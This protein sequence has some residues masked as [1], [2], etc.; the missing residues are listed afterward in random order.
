M[1]TENLEDATVNWAQNPASAQL[2][3]NGTQSKIK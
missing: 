3:N 2:I 1:D